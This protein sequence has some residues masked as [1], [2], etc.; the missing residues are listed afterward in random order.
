MRDPL[1]LQDYN[2]TFVQRHPHYGV[3][4]PGQTWTTRSKPLSD[5]MVRNHLSGKCAVGTLARYY[6][7]YAILDI[8]DKPLEYAQEVRSEL[9]LDDTNSILSGSES[10]DSYHVILKPLY[11]GEPPTVNLLQNIMRDYALIRGIEIYPQKNRVIRLPFGK[12]QPCLDAIYAHLDAWEDKLYW[13]KKLDE[14]DLSTFP[15]HQTVLTF[16]D[17]YVQG[18]RLSSMEEG[19]D[20]F[21]HGLQ[22]FSSRHYSQFQVLYYLWRHN[23]PMD[24][25]IET[26]YAWIKRMHNGFSKDVIRY[27]QRCLS[28]I[29]RQA[30]HIYTKYNSRG[31]YPD[32][33]H[34][35]Q[36]GYI[37]E[38]DVRRI[39]QIAGSIDGL[40]VM[41]VASFLFGIVKYSY[42]RR[43]RHQFPVH[44]DKLIQWSSRRSY[45]T[46]L[47][48]LHEKDVV[49]RGSSYLAG[50]YSKPLTVNW[51]YG[52]SEHAIKY[53]GRAVDTL[54][55]TVRVIY[56]PDEIRT[57][58]KGAGMKRAAAHMAVERIYQSKMFTN[59]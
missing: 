14:V 30:S 29:K 21:E 9:S 36:N 53:D 43:Y 22:H 1:S 34:N 51:S 35:S 3:K 44:T 10:P 23:V 38:P 18:I 41:P 2:S 20:L 24:V 11:N 6:P 52:Q 12:N 55:D 15:R 7:E 45:G 57:I 25:A 46:Y 5:N 47:N 58:L 56:K 8:D 32:H 26:T 54:S 31:I 28:E 50:Q 33:T 37:T 40:S 13:F 19:R 48:A 16:P 27:P 39:F 59:E 17:Q 49:H 42:P 4:F